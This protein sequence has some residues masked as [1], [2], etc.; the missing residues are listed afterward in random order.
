MKGLL[1]SVFVLLTLSLSAQTINDYYRKNNAV[2]RSVSKKY[3]I[4][5]DCL[6][7]IAAK[8]T[9][10]GKNMFAKINNPFKIECFST[11]CKSGHCYNID[12]KNHKVF[13][14]IYHNQFDSY[15]AFCN[16]N[17]SKLKTLCR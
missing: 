5:Y 15:D 14:I 12:P 2:A 9:N 7:A 1:C 10:N 13:Y 3:N 6:L 16:L 8:N 4:D 17:R 11:N